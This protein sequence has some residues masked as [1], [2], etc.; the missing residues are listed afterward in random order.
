M[1]HINDVVSLYFKEIEHIDK[2]KGQ[3]FNIGG[4]IG[5]SLSLLELFEILEK[6][7]DVELR[8]EKLPW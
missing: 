1:L 8:Y 3:A 5:N 2:A 7:L 6:E 4:G